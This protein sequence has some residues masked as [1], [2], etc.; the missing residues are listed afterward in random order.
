MALLLE[1]SGKLIALNLYTTADCDTILDNYSR[2]KAVQSLD[3]NLPLLSQ[4]DLN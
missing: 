4:S 3:S 1:F 2:L